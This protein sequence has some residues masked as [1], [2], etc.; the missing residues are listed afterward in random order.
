MRPLE[1]LFVLIVAGL[2]VAQNVRGLQRRY[3]FA[4][5]VAGLST[6]LLSGLLGQVRWQMTPAYLLFVIL[7]LLLLRRSFSYVGV[8]S[9]GVALG[10]VLL[11]ISAVASLGLPILTLPA[12]D[13]PHVVGVTSLAL[14]DDTRDNSFFNAPDEKRELYIQI[15]YPGAIAAGQPAPRAR[16]LWE[17][18]HRGDLD[19]FTVFS[20]YLRGVETHS[21]EEIPFSPA[22]ADYPAIIFSHAMGS[23]PEQSTLLME[24]LA[25]HGYVVLATSHPYASMR[26]MSG[27]GRAIYVD[28]D[29]LNEISAPFDAGA[30]DARARM[31]QAGST[32]ER[33]RLLLER[34]ESADGLNALMATWVDDLG[35]VLDS[36]TTPSGRDPKLQAISDRIDADWIGLLGMSFGGGAVTELCKSDARCRAGMN[37]DGGTFGQRQREPLQVPFLGMN[38]ENQDYLDYLRSASRSDYY[39]VEVKG[40]TH[41]DFTDDA[42]VLPIL[43]WL[44]IT[45]DIEG[46]RV[47][48]ITNAVS[49]RF[50][51]A[52]LRGGPKPRFSAEFPELTIGMNDYARE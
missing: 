26:V 31:E 27:S 13:G 48:E 25:S 19:L 1:V 41:L 6:I 17:E 14:I 20:S 15:W 9:L 34:Y 3:L 42:V 36:I 12:P 24:H 52:Y 18:L 4:L 21:Y 47:I 16:T 30:A 5:A 51:D 45:G 7:S 23:F 46:R 33:T 39:A 22:Q 40:A 37:M 38:R 29:K 49:L 44:N 8:R 2:L 10:I 11:A 35:F 50:F 28:L 43:K 32:E